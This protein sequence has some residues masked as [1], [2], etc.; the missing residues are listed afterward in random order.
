MVGWE[1]AEFKFIAHAGVG[2]VGGRPLQI[3]GVLYG[4]DGFVKRGGIGG[5]ARERG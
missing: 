5:E 4:Q 2:G 1:D 3:G